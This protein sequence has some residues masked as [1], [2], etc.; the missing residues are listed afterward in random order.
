MN[1]SNS[2]RLESYK[3]RLDLYYQA[4]EKVLNG[5]SYTLGKRSVTRADLAEIRVAIK[6]LESK[7]QALE[8]NGTTKRK[9]ARIIPR[10]F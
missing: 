3:R 9:V 8:T 5:Q 4:E 1:Q 7:I 2:L 6:D 10:D